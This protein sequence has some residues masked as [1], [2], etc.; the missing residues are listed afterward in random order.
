M[1]LGFKEAAGYPCLTPLPREW[2]G[3]AD[4]PITPPGWANLGVLSSLQLRNLLAQIAY[5]L[6]TW[7]YAAIGENNKLGRYQ[8]GTDLLESYGLIIAGANAEYGTNC[9]NYRHVWQPI[10]KTG[11]NDYQNYFYNITS[12]Y[13]FLDNPA[14]QEHLAYQYIVDLYTNCT[15]NNAI[16][17]TDS[18]DVVAGMI[19][20]AWILG[21]GNSPMPSSVNGTG[22]WAWRYNN[23]GAGVN[24]FNSGRYSVLVLSQ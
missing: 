14:A 12:L 5:D 4:A 13:G 16:Q 20:V 2:L 1:S 3:R 22:A 8:L 23:I 11:I 15:N 17:S 19:Y 9:V 6:S 7:D 21:A 18:A 10:N 24:S